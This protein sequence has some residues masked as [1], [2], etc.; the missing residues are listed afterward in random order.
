MFYR[1]RL[2]CLVARKEISFPAIS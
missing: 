2:K 1:C